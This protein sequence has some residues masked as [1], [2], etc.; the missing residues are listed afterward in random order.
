[1]RRKF[2]MYLSHYG[3]LYV[4]NYNIGEAVYMLL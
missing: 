3:V 4:D 1:M 2:A